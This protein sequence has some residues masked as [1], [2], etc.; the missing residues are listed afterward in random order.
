MNTLVEFLLAR[1]AEDEEW[2]RYEAEGWGGRPSDGSRI[3]AECDAK[4]RIVERLGSYLSSD[5]NAEPE[6]AWELLDDHA[7]ATLY[8][9]ALPY[10]SHP[11]YREEWRP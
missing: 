1:I 3:L 7:W 11:D 8:D 10:S 2:A 6:G 5:S 9:L 4:R